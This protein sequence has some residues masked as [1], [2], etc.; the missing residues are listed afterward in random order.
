MGW[1][2]AMK[3]LR[4]GHIGAGVQKLL[5]VA[6]DAVGGPV[7][8]TDDSYHEIIGVNGNKYLD[9][10]NR[11]T[12]NYINSTNSGDTQMANR[13]YTEEDIN[14]KKETPWYADLLNTVVQIG[15]SYIANR[16]IQKQNQQFNASEAQKQRN[17]ETYM[18]NTAYQR[19]YADLLKAGLNPNLAGGGGGAST[20]QGANAASANAPY[21]DYTAMANINLAKKQAENLEADS[22]LKEKQSGKTDQEI[23][24]MKIENQYKDELEK[25]RVMTQGITNEKLKA[26]TEKTFQEIH[27]MEKELRK[28]D[29]E[30]NILKSQGKVAEA[31]AKTKT[32]N[33][34][35]YAILEMAESATRSISNIGG[36]IKGTPAMPI[37]TQSSNVATISNI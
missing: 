12:Y 13:A 27:N 25:L 2:S 36:A 34:R 15:A 26:E 33:R 29:E 20:P 1:G 21:M 19:G 35:A 24:G 14:S 28:I 23:L 22:D 31:E 16:E 11:E 5:G 7:G 10:P 17:Y 4:H 9:S 18:S 37:T 8:G 6:N 30:I 32:R 3:S